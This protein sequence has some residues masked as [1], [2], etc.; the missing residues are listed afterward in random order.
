MSPAHVS[1]LL[2]LQQIVRKSGSSQPTLISIS[3]FIVAILYIAS[4][5]YV[6]ARST[7]SDLIGWSCDY[8]T[9]EDKHDSNS[10]GLG[11][12]CTS[13]VCIP[14]SFFSSFHF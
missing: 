4:L 9:M 7:S 6:R 14:F 12:V 13:I 10:I 2:T 11:T 8:R 5:A 3:S 1:R